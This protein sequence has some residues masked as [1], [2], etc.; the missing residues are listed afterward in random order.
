MTANRRE[1]ARNEL[2]VKNW[3]V[4]RIPGFN[5]KTQRRREAAKTRR[6]WIDANE[7]NKSRPPQM[8]TDRHGFEVAAGWDAVESVLT[9]I[10]ASREQMGAE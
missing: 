1:W 2:W 4:Q 7:G 5:A 3:E 10:F 8:N 6:G 9:G